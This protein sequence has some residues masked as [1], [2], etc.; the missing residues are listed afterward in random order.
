MIIVHNSTSFIT[1]KYL[2]CSEKMCKKEHFIASYLQ[3]EPY[4]GCKSL[5]ML[6][7][8]TPSP[9]Q[10][11]FFERLLT[12]FINNRYELLLLARKIDWKCFEKEFA[13][14]YSHQRPTG[15]SYTLYG[16]VSVAQK[17]L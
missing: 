16:R 15:S 5:Q 1:L 4:L 13:D 6:I 17:A 2:I 7:G 12:D 8:K 10:R 9:E 14:L 3:G 11:N